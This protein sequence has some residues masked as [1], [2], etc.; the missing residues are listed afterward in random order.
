MLASSP[1]KHSLSQAERRHHSSSRLLDHHDMN[2]G[3]V[4]ENNPL[5]PRSPSPTS[6]LQQGSVSALP[7]PAQSSR[8][9]AHGNFAYLFTNINT[10]G[11]STAATTTSILT[12]VYSSPARPWLLHI[13]IRIIDRVHH[14]SALRYECNTHRQLNFANATGTNLFASGALSAAPQRLAAQARRPS[15]RWLPWYRHE[16]SV[17][18]IRDQCRQWSIVPGNNLI[19]ISSTTFSARAL[20]TTSSASTT[21]ARW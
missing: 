8:N 6:P 4:T 16:L 10:F 19:N 1:A 2:A 9:P 17:R 15:P 11:T 7:I 14:R 20:T 12:K 3:N 18:C 21:A 13:P 5:P